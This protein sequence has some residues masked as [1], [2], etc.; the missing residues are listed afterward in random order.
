VKN[1]A[2]LLTCYN[3]KEKTLLCIKKVMEQEIPANY[4]LDIF[5]TDDASNDGTG[6]EVKKF[7]PNVNV[8]N[9]T[10]S[11]FWSGG[12]RNSWGNALI[13]DPDYYLLLNDDTFLFRDAIK[14]ILEHYINFYKEKSSQAIFIGSTKDIETGIISYGGRKLYSLNRPKGHL[15]QSNT[16]CVE[17]DLGEANI[18]LV[19]RIIVQKIGILSDK[20]THGIADYDYTLRAKK[21]GFK[22][23]VTPGILGTC[24]SDHGNNWKAA[25]TNLAERIKYLYSPKGLA[26]KEYLYYIRKHFPLHLPEAIFKLWLKTLFPF[27]YDRFKK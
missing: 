21:E 14:N 11:L 15:I 26:Y 4:H 7:F 24:T 25:D 16:H 8:Y 23:I 22:V 1:I 5:L 9:G 13:T 19:P 10:G 12:M 6:S 2:V 27:V 17:C 3:R 20:F 18:M